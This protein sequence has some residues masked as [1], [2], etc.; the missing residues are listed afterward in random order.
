MD[1]DLFMFYALTLCFFSFWLGVGS[2]YFV[3]SQPRQFRVI[4]FWGLVIFQ[5]IS[6]FFSLVKLLR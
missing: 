1:K 4:V 2:V 5:I 6:I 3:N